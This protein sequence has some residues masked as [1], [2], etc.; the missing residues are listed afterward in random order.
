M[1]PALPAEVCVHV[2]IMWVAPFLG[3]R[4]K[5]KDGDAGGT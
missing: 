4:S 2:L 1:R 3:G 5:D